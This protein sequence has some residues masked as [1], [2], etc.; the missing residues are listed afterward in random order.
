[1]SNC[2]YLIS[3]TRTPTGAVLHNSGST[4]AYRLS[5]AKQL[6]AK[7][8][9]ELEGNDYTIINAVLMVGSEVAVYDAAQ[10]LTLALST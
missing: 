2:S 5:E 3:Y 8:L 10:C 7:Q 9:N 4:R 6:L 1:M